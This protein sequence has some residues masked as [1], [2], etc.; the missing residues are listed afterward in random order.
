MDQSPPVTPAAQTCPSCGAAANGRFCSACGAALV[1]VACAACGTQLSPGARFCHRCGTPAGQSD[2]PRDERSFS[3]A[4]PWGVAAIALVALIALVAGQR[5]GRSASDDAGQTQAAAP[6]TGAPGQP[7]DLS[8]M[9][10]EDAAA[11]LYDRV[12]SLHERGRADSVQIFAPMAMQAYEMLGKLNLDQRYDLGRIAAVAGDSATA[13]AQADTILAQHPN[14]LL[15]LI[16]AG[17]AAR[18]RHDAAAEKSFHDKLVAAAPAERA[19][20]LTEYTTHENDI[21]IALDSKRP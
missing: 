7:P 17:N 10:P 6:A 5:F 16:L 13:R 18:M 2:G 4:L 15:G 19:K 8:S 14:H 3:S 21:T 9:T 1:G 20:Q 12:M 11:R